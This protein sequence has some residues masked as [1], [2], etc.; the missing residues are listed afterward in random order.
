[1]SALRRTRINKG[2]SIVKLAERAGVSEDQIRGIEN[3]AV[4]NPRAQ[5]LGKLATVLEVE[6]A[7][8]DPILARDAADV[9]DAADPPS[10]VAA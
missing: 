2:L 6:P 8:L 3:G 1:V 7:F 9:A 10:H 5:T 4:M